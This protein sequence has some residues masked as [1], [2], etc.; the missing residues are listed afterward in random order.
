MVT[1]FFSKNILQ[2]TQMLVAPVV[3]M[4]DIE[5]YLDSRY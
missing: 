5:K 2:Q 3:E 4:F 1:N